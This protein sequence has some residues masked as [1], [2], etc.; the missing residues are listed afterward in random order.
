MNKKITKKNNEPW[1]Q[2]TIETPETE[3]V[4]ENFYIE[5]TSIKNKELIRM[6]MNIVQFPIFSK[7]TQRK[8]NQ[9]VKYY[10]NKNRD[11]Y[12]TVTPSAG[13]Y[14]PGETEEKVFIALMQLMK[15]KGM[16]RKFVISGVELRDKLNIS[17]IRYGNIVK[18][19]LLRL[20]ETNYNFKNTMYS[21]EYNGVINKE[22]ST[23]ILTLEIITLSLK[24]NQQYREIYED[25]R[26]KEVYEITIT[27]HFYQNIIQKGYMVYNSGILLN[28]STSTARTIYMLIEKMRFE[29][30]YLKIDTIFLIKRIPLKYD[31]KHLNTTIKTLEKAFIE[32]RGKEL[33]EDF[34][35]I[36]DSTWDKSEIEIFF[37]EK[38]KEEKQQRFF[39]DRNDFRKILTE[40]TISD[41]EHEII[42]SLEII[43]K[44]SLTEAKSES[45]E[46]NNVIV[47]EEM[48]DKI[49][50]LMPSKARELKTMPK[51][52]KES[53][54]NYGYKKVE[55]L[56]IYMKKNKVEKIRAYFLKALSEN[57]EIDQDTVDI[58][59][60][61]PK[62]EKAVVVEKE[63]ISP[64][65]LEKINNY[66]N[67]LTEL[68][69]E[70]LEKKVYRDYI[71]K[72]GSETKIQKLA[73][74]NG[75]KRIT[76]KYILE[77]INL[78]EVNQEVE[79]P[80][81][82]EVRSELNAN[83]IGALELKE[84]I[85]NSLNTY[86]TFLDFTDEEFKELHTN[87]SFK[88]TPHFV[89]NTITLEIVNNILEVELKEF[90]KNRKG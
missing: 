19:A 49:F 7:N 72:C 50:G 54:E 2:E 30:I 56:A 60:E 86:R 4:E 20:S 47:T 66:L 32:L 23:P 36:K 61:K 10:F 55:S 46:K 63:D 16:P 48:I 75:K 17:T 9:V 76:E 78:D 15:E 39:E 74:N 22:I 89:T 52:I 87:V 71:N 84:Y 77:N 45:Q 3:Y 44:D 35:I 40:T 37:H 41:T 26:I 69:K 11:T 83:V 79:E 62:M 1:W 28:I 12:I 81:K 14:I 70:E 67:N 64:I 31:K 27:D 43:E 57:W 88:V 34:K 5:E 53:I 25:K 65:I 51:T 85:L 38:S 90:Q 18:N 59:S 6:D 13:N 42:D 33:I 29:N 68:E 73:F 24:K 80:T 8:V 58:F 82:E 21:S